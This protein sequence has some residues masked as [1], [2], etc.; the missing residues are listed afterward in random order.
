MSQ[1]KGGKSRE[2]SVEGVLTSPAWPL[3]SAQSKPGKVGQELS[4]QLTSTTT[5]V[6][7]NASGNILVQ[8]HQAA[9]GR[10]LARFGHFGSKGNM[11]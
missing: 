10:A 9:G 11:G 2:E 6:Y 1:Y 3:S 8:R 5:L 4:K 7:C